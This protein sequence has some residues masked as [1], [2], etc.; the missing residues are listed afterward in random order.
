MSSR[1]RPRPDTAAP[2]TRGISKLRMKSMTTERDAGRTTA[3]KRVSRP[4]R[5]NGGALGTLRRL[6]AMQLGLLLGPTA[7]WVAVLIVLPAISMF[8][9]SFW[10]VGDAG[11]IPDFTFDNYQRIATRYVYRDTLLR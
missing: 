9:I 1:P 4:V 8:V 10:R 6:P 7:L 5:G 3:D 2:G 11:L